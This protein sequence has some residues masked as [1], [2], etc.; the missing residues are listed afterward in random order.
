[1]ITPS[2]GTRSQDRSMSTRTKARKRALDILFESELRGADPLA[3]LRE[4]SADA[5]PPVRDY[6]KQLVEGVTANAK[7]ID[8]RISASLAPGWT[9]ERTPR[10]DRNTLRIAVFEIDFSELPD[11]VAVSEALHLVSE[12][13]TDESPA[14]VN[15]VLG[16]I[17]AT[18]S[19]S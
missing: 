4:R 9:L 10:V 1:V 18:K 2:A 12:L 3:T 17:I 14:F 16:S 7:A 13:S 5:D 11:Q 6:T 19:T 8:A 15:G